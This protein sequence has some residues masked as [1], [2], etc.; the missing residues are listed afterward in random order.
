LSQAL[1]L[2]KAKWMKTSQLCHQKYLLEKGFF[3]AF[4]E[5]IFI[6]P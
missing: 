2:Q 1:Q 6:L 3:G 4:I 5:P